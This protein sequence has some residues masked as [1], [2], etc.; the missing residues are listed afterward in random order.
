MFMIQMPQPLS[1]GFIIMEW[2]FL[3]FFAVGFLMW[4]A[5]GIECLKKPVKVGL[6]EEGDIWFDFP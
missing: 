4:G 1:L 2:L 6:S 5:G 3:R